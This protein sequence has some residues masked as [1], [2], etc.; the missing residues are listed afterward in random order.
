MSPNPTVFDEVDKW[1]QKLDIPARVTAGSIDNYVY[2][3]RYARAEVVGSVVMQLYGGPGLNL[4][5]GLYGGIPGNSSYPASGPVGGGGYPTGYPA[6]YGTQNSYGNYGG[7]YQNTGYPNSMQNAGQIAGP[8]AGPGAGAAYPSASL[9]PVAAQAGTGMQATANPDRTGSF[10]GTP[11]AGGYGYAGPRIIPNPFD[12]TLL[13]QGTP[14]QWV[15]IKHLLEQLDIAPR[16]VLIDAKIY[17]IDLTGNL[18]YGV[19]S[20]LQKA[21]TANAAVPAQQVLGSSTPT[22]GIGGAAGLGLTAGMLVGQS[23]QLLA[24]LQASEVASKTKVLSAPSIIATDSI[25]ASITVG[26]SVPTLTSTSATGVQ[27]GGNTQFAQTIQNTSTGI[28]LTILARVNPSGVVTM[29]INQ[30]VTAPVPTTTS[31][32]DS[33]SFSQRN[34]STQVTVEDG[35]TV[36]IGGII[37]NSDSIVSSGIPYLDRIPYLGAAFGTKTKTTSRTELIVFL[38]PRVIYDTAQM[39]DATDE[40]KDE[41]KDLRKMMR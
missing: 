32:I 11:V 35:D 30:N 12:N 20:F 24:Y 37:M 13:V 41:L 9:G 27:T 2:R 39:T 25:P 7:G 6:S 34:V 38:T 40:L 36:A 16:Q 10:L 28:G 22:S 23:R 1:I 15:Q 33:P 31:T 5:N 8:G 29:V 14:E 26:S 19:E 17:E 18:A 4:S 3:L 21:G